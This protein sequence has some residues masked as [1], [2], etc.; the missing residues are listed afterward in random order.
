MHDRWREESGELLLEGGEEGCDFV[1]A[2]RVGDM[3]A[4][5][6][7]SVATRALHKRVDGT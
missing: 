1:S 6:C 4:V 5:D 3:K 7:R 2:T